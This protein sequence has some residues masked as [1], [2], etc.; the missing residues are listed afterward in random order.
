M[1]SLSL[2]LYD[3]VNREERG[4][5]SA[6]RFGAQVAGLP[7]ED[8]F[9][10]TYPM[11]TL[12]SILC[13]IDFSDQSRQALRWAVALAAR[14]QSRLTVLTA[15]D[16][17]LAEAA[18]VRLGLDLAKA[19]VEPELR[20]FVKAAVPESLSWAARPVL[21]VG[22][23]NAPEV[24]LRAA[25]R[26][27]AELIVLGT[28]GLG[29]FRK[30]LLGSTTE[31][32]LR[33]S[34]AAVLAVPLSEARAVALEPSG[35]RFDVYRV[36][37]ATDFSPPASAALQWA[38]SLSEEL[39]VQLLLVHVVSPVA[40]APRW[41]SYVTEVDEEQVRQARAR[42]ESLL[43]EHPGTMEREAVVSIGRP[44]ESIASTADERGAGLIVM[45]LT[46]QGEASRPGSIAYQVLCTAHVPVL[47]VPL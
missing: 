9:G 7:A 39:K 41:R 33:R 5:Q 1:V 34:K 14:H 19:E 18:K 46:G 21:D 36:M 24:I 45:G 6:A 16:P 27:R 8:K 20:E 30:L 37:M 4:Q 25:E 38:V 11:T 12:R 35:P 31:Q 29:G 17:L 26:E 43:R 22:I 23:G 10:S 47:V 32:V 42:L 40:V 13:P 15:V 2:C 28:H 44:A 3:N